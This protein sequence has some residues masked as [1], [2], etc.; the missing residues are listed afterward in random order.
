MINQNYKPRIDGLRFL[1]ISSVLLFHF[2]YYIG[3][4][5]SA[6][7][8]GVNL[9]FVLSGFLITSILIK[10]DGKGFRQRYIN[11]LGRRFLRIFPIYYLTIFLLLLIGTPHVHERLFYLLTYTYN[12]IVPKIDWLKEYV[13]H[14]WSLSV[15][16]QFYVFF[17]LLAILLRN[18]LKVLILV[19]SFL[20]I[21]AYLQVFFDI[22]NIGRFYEKVVVFNYTSLLTNMAPL[23]IGAIGAIL[24]RR[25]GVPKVFL[26]AWLEVFLFISI[27]LTN[28]FLAWK[29]QILICSVCNIFLVIKA[30]YSGFSIAWFDKLVTNRYAVYIGRI[31]YGLYIYHAILNC[32][33]NDYLFDPLWVKIPF[34]SLGRFWKLEFHSWIFKLPLYTLIS[35][36]IAHLSFVYIEKPILKLKDRYFRS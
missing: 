29:F 10:E 16:E 20:V 9:F 26:S 3:N 22:F 18:R 8:Y 4:F 6:G 14:F 25:H 11:F 30:Y 28:C 5:F 1:A 12:F 19:C 35:V 17:P 31:S 15:E 2:A 32:Y 23:S 21:I 34:H 27:L 7:S 24:T 33:F 13:G 36:F